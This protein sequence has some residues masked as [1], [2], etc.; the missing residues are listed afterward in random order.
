MDPDMLSV[1]ADKRMAEPGSGQVREAE[2]VQ[3]VERR[4][5]EMER[6]PAMKS[7]LA[8]L[9]RMMLNAVD[10]RLSKAERALWEKQ[11]FML[12]KRIEEAGNR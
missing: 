12:A 1:R 8:R 11:A 4:D 3:A 10:K 5:R 9:T 6:R 2:E 7:T